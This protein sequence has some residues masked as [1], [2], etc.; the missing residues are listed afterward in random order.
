MKIETVNLNKERKLITL[1][2]MNDSFCSSIVSIL[3]PEV[4]VTPYAQ[5]VADWAKEYYEKYNVAPKS[6][7]S[8]VY[9]EHVS[10]IRNTDLLEN[11]KVFLGSLATDYHA[12]MYTNLPFY[13]DEAET[14]LRVLGL[15]AHCT[16]VVA[17]AECGKLSQAEAE[18]GK[19]NQVAVAK[20]VGISVL[21]DAE[22]VVKLLTSANAPS[23]FS[24]PGALGDVIGEVHRQ[25]FYACVA[26]MKGTKSWHLLNIDETAAKAGCKVLHV[27]LEMREE[28]PLSRFVRSLLWKPLQDADV[29]MPKFVCDDAIPTNSS[30]WRIEPVTVHK[31]G[32]VLNPVTLKNEI[33]QR[34][35]GDNIRIVSLP[36]GS[37]TVKDIEA[38]LDNLAKYENY[39][40]D[41]LTID[42]CD[43]LGS[44]E[45]DTRDKLNDI[46]LNLRRVAQERNI[47]VATV[48]QSN[49]A[50][51]SGKELKA[52]DISEDIRK[53]AHVTHFTT[54]YG[55]EEQMKNGYYCVR[56]LDT[57]YKRYVWESAIVTQC[58]DIGRGYVDSRLESKVIQ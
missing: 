28:E 18:A 41:V 26:R 47:F 36:S 30:M 5:T 8:D 11:I 22:K 7:I 32:I 35:H 16:R 50:G 15:K 46:W 3:K 40:P 27:D 12:E 39:V 37:T 6:N 29:V 9:E 44:K 54:A 21:N 24:F 56:L 4:L 45:R 25:D 10:T 33:Y 19:F 48:T 43:L 51:T 42:Y 53:L 52:S 38:L 57:R 13:V 14:Y 31:K 23:L 2:I 49:R 20:N 34:L 55:T 58:F 1:L 17:L